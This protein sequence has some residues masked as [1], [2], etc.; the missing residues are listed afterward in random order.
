MTGV[1]IVKINLSIIGIVTFFVLLAHLC[2]YIEFEYGT[3]W[4]FAVLL[5]AILI[6]LNVLMLAL[7]KYFN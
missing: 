2:V 3:G 5:T 7:N 1:N 4:A 6:F